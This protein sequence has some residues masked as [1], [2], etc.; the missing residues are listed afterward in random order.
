[1][2]YSAAD[3]DMKIDPMRGHAEREE[4]QAETAC[5]EAY[6]ESVLTIDMRSVAKSFDTCS[7]G[8][9]FHVR[10]A[11]DDVAELRMVCQIYD[12]NRTLV[13]E[14]KTRGKE[15]AV[16]MDRETI[17]LMWTKLD[18]KKITAFPEYRISSQIKQMLKT[19]NQNAKIIT[20]CPRVVLKRVQQQHGIC[21]FVAQMDEGAAKSLRSDDLFWT[22]SRAAAEMKQRPEWLWH[23]RQCHLI[24]YEMDK[25]P[26]ISKL[27]R[28]LP[29]CERDL[30]VHLARVW[31][32]PAELKTKLTKMTIAE[33]RKELR[34]FE[35]SKIEKDGKSEQKSA[36]QDAVTSIVVTFAGISVQD[37]PSMSIPAA[38]A[39]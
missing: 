30:E 25:N 36:S 12:L 10:V 34:D 7:S 13:V 15:Q 21:T 3:Y 8:Q 27:T 28:R 38:Q 14:E 17:G 2:S 5:R 24:D 35:A 20:D 39:V 22:F 18:S 6:E 16:S 32:L 19:V 37:R 33:Q 4:A 1:M 11:F 31:E 26:M 23:R 9:L 29:M